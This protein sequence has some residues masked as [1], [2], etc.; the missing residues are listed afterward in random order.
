MTST[1]EGL[2]QLDEIA[3]GARVERHRREL[4]VHCYRMLGWFEESEDLVQ[5]TFLR[6]WRRRESYAGRASARAWLYRIA[7]NACLD[8]LD[9]RPR[10][11][12]ADGEVLWLQPYPDA[13]LEEL[14]DGR[15]GARPGRA[16]GRGALERA[17]GGQPRPRHRVP[18][19]RLLVDGEVGPRDPAPGCRA[20]DGV[21]TCGRARAARGEYGE[22]GAERSYADHRHGSDRADHERSRRRARVGG[23]DDRQ[24][25]PTGGRRRIAA[26]AGCTWPR[27]GLRAGPAATAVCARPALTADVRLGRVA[28]MP[29]N[30]CGAARC[31]LPPGRQA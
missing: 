21:S 14:P 3:F 28:R 30:S 29:A 16:S 2:R 15:E 19:G 6:A 11:P 18:T 27:L 12:T 8:A 25:S 1:S 26:A 10:T 24:P 31:L 5:E 22:H 13:L 23:H 7:T 17:D 20:R 9:K 4:H